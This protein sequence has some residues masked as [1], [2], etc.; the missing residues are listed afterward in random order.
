M[1]RPAA[2]CHRAFAASAAPAQV[3]ADQQTLEA[4]RV[5]Q[6]GVS[7]LEILFGEQ[8][9]NRHDAPDVSCAQHGRGRLFISIEM[10]KKTGKGG[11]HCDG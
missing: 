4:R 10:G 8:K 2:D 6:T 9:Q 7:R 11:G 1:R 3:T 5:E